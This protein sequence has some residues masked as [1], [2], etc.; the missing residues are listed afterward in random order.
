MEFRILGPLEAVSDE[1]PVKVPGAKPR[2]VLAMLLVNANQVVSRDRLVED[3]WAGSPPGSPAATLQTYVYQLRRALD[4]DSLQTQADGYR[5]EV[6]ENAVDALRFE[7]AVQEQSQAR[8]TSPYQRSL[9]LREALLWWR[10]PALAGFSDADWAKLPASRLEELRLTAIEELTDVRLELGEHALLVPELEAQ[11][12]EHPLRERRWRQL[13]LALYR[14]DRQADALR[15]HQRVRALLADELGLDPGAELVNLERAILDHDPSLLPPVPPAGSATTRTPEPERDVITS[16]RTGTP[17]PSP[18]TS[19]VGRDTEVAAVTN[20]L[21]HHRLVTLK[22]PGGAGKTRLAIEV[23][24]RVTAV[25]PDGVHFADLAAVNDEDQVG[26]AIVAALGLA[27]DPSRADTSSRLARFL[28][29]RSALC[30]VDNCEHVIDACAGIAEA[31]LG[32]G[33]TSRLLATSRQPLGVVGEQVYAVPSLDSQ[34]EAV[35]LFAER[36]AAARAGFVVDESNRGTISEICRRLDG[37]PL[38]IELAAARVAH[39]S[40]SQLLARLEDRF[41]LLTAGRRAARHQTLAATLDWSYDLLAEQE[42]Q[43]LRF[44]AAFPASFSLEAA[45]AVVGRDGAFESLASLVSSSLVQIVD[46]GDDLRYRLLETV[47]MYAADR[48]GPGE[49]EQA[50]MRHRDW[51]LDLIESI[52][53]EERMLGDVDRLGGEGPNIRAALEW[54]HQQ[55]DLAA[56]HRIAGNVNWRQSDQ[57][58]DGARWLRLAA[59]RADAVTARLRVPVYAGISRLMQ[60]AAQNADDWV[61]AAGWAEHAIDAAQGTSS[62]EHAEVLGVRAVALSVLALRDNS[63]K[64]AE[65]AVEL[66]EAGVAMTVDLGV[67]WRMDA[68][69]LAGSAYSVLAIGWPRYAQMAQHHLAAGV[70]L[71]PP[72]PPFLGLRAE[73]V[74]HLATWRV[75]AG[76]VQGACELAREARVDIALTP[77]SRT[78]A[79]LAL[80]LILALGSDDD[81]GSLGNAVRSF[82]DDARRFD[83]GSGARDTVII[84]GG[85]LAALGDEWESAARLLAAG[86]RG[87]YGSD[88]TGLMHQYFRHRAREVIGA[89]VARELRTEGRAMPPSDALEAALS[90]VPPT[91]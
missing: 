45:E 80:A 42:R 88:L 91:A 5:L 26:D 52:P 44:L 74:A 68:R 61:A 72:Q 67:P 89:E 49:A 17:V 40:P 6:K 70:D 64:V 58:R 34:T 78:A 16:V 71:S 81:V 53:R 54:S 27:H 7:K 30:V 22:G 76:D 79:R 14:C 69:A 66:A 38:A 8:D 57:W 50:R 3:L 62:A 24:T 33:G 13:I 1:G 56:V 60:L 73:L 19:F 63:E 15:A 35:R 55:G 12:A 20:L 51:M 25:F 37:L 84:Y 23:A 59:A 29:E 47:R 75:L 85:F 43:A 18:P 11:V 77:Y 83:W 9:R 28:G 21:E 82:H 4:L 86:E 10:G 2:A 87:V 41:Q 31:V 39:L 36:A 46:R 90:H 48:C 32:R 65:Q